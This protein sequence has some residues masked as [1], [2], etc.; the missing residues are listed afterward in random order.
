MNDIKIFENDNLNVKQA[1]SARELYSNLTNGDMS[2]YSRWVK[3]NIIDND[4]ADENVDYILFA[5]MA[6]TP[7]D[8]DLHTLGGR[9]TQDYILTID[10][11][12]ELCMLSKCAKGKEIRK[13]FIEC[14]KKLKEVTRTPQTY[15]EA[16]KALVASEEERQLLKEQTELMKPKADFYDAVANTE[17]LTSFADT[18]KLLDKGIGRN[19]LMKL[20]REKKILQKDNIPYQ[21]YVDRGYFKVVESC[22][23]ANEN[24]VVSYTTYVKQKGI[25]YI[26]KLLV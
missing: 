15:L 13:Y 23:M 22:Y 25:D 2:H 12:K 3:Q 1:V 11:A 26:R 20:L 10:F 8:S 18:A 6:K 14:E 4:F 17:S 19:K 21:T 16:L 5:T 9:P 7:N 24:K